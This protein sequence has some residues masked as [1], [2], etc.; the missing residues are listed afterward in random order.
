MP[1]L[2]R[3]RRIDCAA[4]VT[5]GTT[6]EERD[7]A[8]QTVVDVKPT[9]E[10]RDIDAHRGADGVQAPVNLGAIVLG[11]D[12]DYFATCSGDAEERDPERN[13]D[14]QHKHE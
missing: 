2:S 9:P 8:T 5:C 6:P 13:S 1:R 4:A 12:D 14:G 7:V 10:L 3:R 11:Q